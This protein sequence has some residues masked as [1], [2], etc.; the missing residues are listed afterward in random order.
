[1]AGV[2]HCFCERR[3]TAAGTSAPIASLTP[4]STWVAYEVGLIQQNL[5]AVGFD[6]VLVEFPS[7]GPLGAPLAHNKLVALERPPADP[8]ATLLRGVEGTDVGRPVMDGLARWLLG[9][10]RA[11]D[12]AASTSR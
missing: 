2:R 8:R 12:G 11:R 4:I 7:A 9:Q 6:R 1:M 5:D 10:A 3:A